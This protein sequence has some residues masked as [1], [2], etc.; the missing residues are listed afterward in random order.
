MCVLKSLF[1]VYCVTFHIMCNM[2]MTQNLANNCSLYRISIDFPG[3]GWVV[4]MLCFTGSAGIMLGGMYRL[5]CVMFLLPYWYILLLDKSAWNNHSYLFGIL[6]FLFLLCDGN[7][8]WSVD[9]FSSSRIRNADVPLWN[10]T[11]LRGQVGYMKYSQIKFSY[12][13]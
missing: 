8:Y 2:H 3:L 7:H 13:L 6:A 4:C 11:L 10:Y 1:W 5:S 12:T 9:G